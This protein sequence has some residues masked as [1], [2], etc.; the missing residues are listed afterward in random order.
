MKIIDFFKKNNKIIFG[1]VFISIIAISVFYFKNK[2]KEIQPEVEKTLLEVVNEFS[3][4][5]ENKEDPEVILSKISDFSENIPE[6]K[7]PDDLLKI[8]ENFSQN[9][10]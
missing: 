7:T 2:K 5:I 4:K 3:E 1:I 6:K 9:N 8:V 10:N